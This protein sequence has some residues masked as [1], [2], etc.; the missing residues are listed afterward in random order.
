[1]SDDPDQVFENSPPSPLD[2]AVL[3][4]HLQE[5]GAKNIVLTTRMSWDGDLGITSAALSNKL[6]TFHRAN[7]GLPLTRGS[8]KQELPD[9]LRQSVIPFSNVSGN[10]RIL[11]IVNQ[12]TVPSAVKDLSLIHI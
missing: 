5:A 9:I 7:I 6:S 3:L 2:Y 11:P 12:V 8:H 4:H 1:M 10:Y